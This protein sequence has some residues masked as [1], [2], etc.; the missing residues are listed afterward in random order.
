MVIST[1][2][3]DLESQPE[4]TSRNSWLRV[5]MMVSVH[6]GLV[7]SRNGT[8]NRSLDLCW[9]GYEWDSDSQLWSR[10]ATRCR[11]RVCNWFPYFLHWL[12]RD[13]SKQLRQ[14]HNFDQSQLIPISFNF[15]SWV[16]SMFILTSRTGNQ[17]I[18]KTY[19][20]INHW[21][22]CI[23]PGLHTFRLLTHPNYSSSHKHTYNRF[24]VK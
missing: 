18:I 20:I 8:R 17:I 21:L 11:N 2:N 15:K 14:F 1:R 5:A 10:L 13:S 23:L 6:H 24:H 12:I 16:S 19:R 3:G 4:I 9:L 7:T 22:S